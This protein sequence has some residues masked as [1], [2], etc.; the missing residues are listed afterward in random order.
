MIG[1]NVD[2]KFTKLNEN[3]LKYSKTIPIFNFNSADI[4]VQNNW[5]SNKVFKFQTNDNTDKLNFDLSKCHKSKIE[6]KTLKLK[7]ILNDEQK[8]ILNNWFNADK[9]MYNITVSFLRKNLPYAI[10]HMY[11]KFHDMNKIYFAIKNKIIELNKKKDRLKST[12]QKL[13]N[14]YNN[15]KNYNDV[16]EKQIIFYDNNAHI[17]EINIEIQKLQKEQSLYKKYVL[18]FNN[19]GKKIKILTDYQKI[20]TEF[21]A[22]N[23]NQIYDFYKFSA[24]YSHSLDAS[25]KRACSSYK[26]SITN[27]LEG[28]IK[29]FRIKCYNQNNDRGIIEMEKNTFNKDNDK[30]TIAKK[31]LG[32][33]TYLNDGTNYNISKPSTSS[34][35][36]DGH[37]YWLLYT[38]NIEVNNSIK[39]KSEYISLDS[40]I[41]VFQTGFSKDHCVDFGFDVYD[42]IKIYLNKIDKLNEKQTI[43]NEIFRCKNIIANNEDILDKI[44]DEKKAEKIILSSY[45]N[46]S[47]ISKLEKINNNIKQKNKYELYLN[48]RKKNKANFYYDVIKRKINEMH[49]K[50][51]NFLA[52]NYNTVLIGKFSSKSAS[53]GEN[54]NDMVKRVGTIMRHYNFRER[55]VYKCLSFGTNIIV[56]DE[57]YTTKMCS[58]CGHYNAHIKSEKEIKCEGCLI[59]YPRDKYS[60]RTILMKNLI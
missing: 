56:S 29:R 32:N 30:F 35:Y 54:L 51:C 28:N 44:N 9:K 45:F 52:K 21:L 3:I 24:I 40:G 15:C 41:R 26:S 20:R 12:N 47:R 22:E 55:L 27:L 10:I 39:N 8:D 16:W 18:K 7:C 46:N 42:K 59:S 17:K 23:K 43:D 57:K 1:R 48:N 13:Q 19:L 4:T 5:Y 14:Y 11:K 53:Q 60:A 25:I 38:A 31:I 58:L 36:Y 6:Y 2:P 33:I 34:F 37:N 50:T 49:W